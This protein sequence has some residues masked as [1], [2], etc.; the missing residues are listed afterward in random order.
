ML[1]R[2]LAIVAILA[3]IPAAAETVTFTA[4][5]GVEVTADVYLP[6]NVSSS[7]LVLFHMAG[8]SRG[9]YREIAPRLA[10]QGYIS[11]AVDQRSGGAFAGVVNLTAAGVGSDP[12]YSTAIPDLNA[13]VSYARTKLGAA[14]VGVVGSSYSAALVLALAGRDP[15]FADAVIAFSPGEYF[16][17]RRF[18]RDAVAELAAPVFLTAAREET[19]QWV[20]IFDA[21][22]GSN[23]VGFEPSVAGRHGAT[24][25][26]E[27][28][29]GAYW[30]ALE[31]FLTRYLPAR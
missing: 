19:G 29:T 18:V 5:D 6:D 2:I 9:E 13:A 22:P 16:S 14:R 7:V 24:A 11:M 25:L 26:V 28:K 10:K 3:T 4:D 21:I 27:D 31:T 15:G 30:K 17:D 23:K 20:S 8:A 12:G 1:A